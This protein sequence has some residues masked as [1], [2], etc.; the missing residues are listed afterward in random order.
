MDKRL[1]NLETGDSFQFTEGET[2]YNPE[3]W[4]LVEGAY[5]DE[6]VLNDSFEELENEELSNE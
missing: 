5:T 4:E 1:I 6:M 2:S 3:F